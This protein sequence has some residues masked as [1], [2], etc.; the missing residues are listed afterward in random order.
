[1]SSLW[2]SKRHGFQGMEAQE[3]QTSKSAKSFPKCFRP[4]S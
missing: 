3:W 4:G 1:M 2:V